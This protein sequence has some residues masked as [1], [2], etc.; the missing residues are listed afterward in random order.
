MEKTINQNWNLESLYAGGSQSEK[1]KESMQQLTLEIRNVRKELQIFNGS[2]E[3]KDVQNLVKMVLDTQKIMGG[4]EEVDDIIYCLYAQ[5]VKDHSAL[6]LKNES[7]VIKSQLKSLQIE[8]D[9]TLASLAEEEWINFLNQKEVES[10]SF[11]LEE[12]RKA[13]NDQLP[14]RTRENDQYLICKRI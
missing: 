10:I 7:A 5:D 4:W 12:R 8:V 6:I 3:V 13:V 9:R 11:Y 2:I 1:L 14:I